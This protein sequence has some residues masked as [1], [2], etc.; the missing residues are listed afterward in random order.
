[1]RTKEEIKAEID[2]NKAELRKLQDDG[3]AIDKNEYIARNINHDQRVK[4]AA[5]IDCLFWVLVD[6]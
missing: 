5:R 6:Y 4:L 3:E 1:M 2:T